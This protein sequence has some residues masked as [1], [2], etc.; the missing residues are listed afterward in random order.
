MSRAFDIM[1]GRISISDK[2]PTPPKP[3]EPRKSKTKVKARQLRPI[4]I[5]DLLDWE[6][7]V[8][9]AAPRNKTTCGIYFLLQGQRIVYV[10]QSINVHVRLDDHRRDKSKVFDGYA[11]VEC[12]PKMLNA[13]EA[14]YIAKF[15]PKYNSV[16]HRARLYM[17]G[18]SQ[19]FTE[20]SIDQI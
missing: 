16:T 1:M 8:R 17:P 13:I 11:I 4:Q 15:S 10:G 20:N 19:G 12:R 5:P 6:S 9:I 2:P 18:D 3:I 14:A 7:V